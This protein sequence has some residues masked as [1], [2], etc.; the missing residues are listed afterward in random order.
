MVS[1]ERPDVIHILESG[2]RFPQDLEGV[3][4]TQQLMLA[5]YES[6][7]VGKGIFL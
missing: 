3:A 4:D 7:R 2:E 5:V 1:G 6:A